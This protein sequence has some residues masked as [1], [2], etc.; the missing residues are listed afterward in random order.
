M[1]THYS[2]STPNGMKTQIMLEECALPHV[3]EPVPIGKG[4]QNTPAY[5]AINPN[6]KIPAIRDSDG[7][8]GRPFTLFESGAILV[9]LAEKTGRFLPADQA[10]RY[11]ALQWIMLQMG[12]LG[13]M[14]GQF[15]HFSASAPEKIPYAIDRYRNESARLI[16]VID[17]RLAESPYLAGPDY[18]IADMCTWPWVRSWQHTVNQTLDAAPNVKRWYA[19]IY[20][21]AA[22]AKAEAVTLALRN[23][24]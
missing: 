24:S 6:G 21:R 11:R 1:I 17:G 16:G 13:P 4:A 3:I 9:Y 23:Q 14:I 8:D 2:W 19:A 22:V 5:R 12:G 7:P 20:A 18:T 10:A 15:H